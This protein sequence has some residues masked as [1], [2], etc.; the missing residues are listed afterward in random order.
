MCVF[1]CACFCVRPRGMQRPPFAVQATT[2]CTYVDT[3]QG[4]RLVCHVRLWRRGCY[5]VCQSYS[6]LGWGVL[7]CY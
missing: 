5:S 4:L 2:Y 1:S 6:L 7:H 3:G